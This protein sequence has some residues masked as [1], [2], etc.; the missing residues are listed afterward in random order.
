MNHSNCYKSILA[1]RV[2]CWTTTSVLLG[3][4]IYL[5]SLDEDICLVDYKEYYDI[6][7]YTF[8]VLS[9]CIKNPF[10]IS[11]LTNNATDIN[12]ETYAKLQ[13]SC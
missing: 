6:P 5:Y 12:N 9:L 13:I 8:P 10:D 2:I 3:Y 11:N 1:F 7:E 4:W